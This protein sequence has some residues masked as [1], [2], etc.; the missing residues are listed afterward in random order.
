[1]TEQPLQILVR[2][3]DPSRLAAAVFS[4]DSAT[5]VQIHED[6]GGL[7]LRTR[8]ADGFYR[9]MNEMVVEDGLEVEAV[10]PADDNVQAIYQYLL[11]D[12]GAAS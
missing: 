1:M 8:N 12:E 7:H 9:L 10:G 3:D 6:G 11:G 4:Q 2:C 5:E